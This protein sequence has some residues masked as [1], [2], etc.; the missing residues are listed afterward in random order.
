MMFAS[1]PEQTLEWSDSGV[2]G[3]SRFIKRLWALCVEMKNRPDDVFA[4][5][6]DFRIDF[7]TS[8]KDVKAL[9][10][11]IHSTLR[12]VSFDYERTQY[13][14]VVSGTMKMLNALAAFEPNIG[15]TP[16]SG[17]ESTLDIRRAAF[18]EGLGILLR[19]LYPV[20]PHITH[21]L[22]KELGY[23]AKYGDLVAAPWPTSDP[24]A[25]EQDEIELVLQVN[26]KLRGH[27]RAP[28][29]AGREQI[30]RLALAHEAVA[31]F[32]GGQT[33]KKVV[34]VPGRLVNVVV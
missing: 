30:E 1:P 17:N 15:V 22:W 9:R 2:E 7:S 34:V 13:N 29:A 11:L 33:V 21:A 3:S 32:T 25:L 18:V 4:S 31:K 28:K 19:T 8:G 16:G 12:Q 6:T 26:G 20:A 23:V 24:L 5:G 10:L 27:M 14:T